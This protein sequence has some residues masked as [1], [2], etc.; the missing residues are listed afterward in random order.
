MQIRM[1]ALCILRPSSGFKHTSVSGSCKMK[2]RSYFRVII[3]YRVLE[4]VGNTSR[5]VTLS[6]AN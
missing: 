6:G 1:N 2:P 4:I 3:I 5:L